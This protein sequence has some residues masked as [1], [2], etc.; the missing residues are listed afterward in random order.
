MDSMYPDKCPTLDCSDR[1]I[2]YKAGQRSVVNF[3]IQQLNLQ[4]KGDMIT[5]V[6]I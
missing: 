6:H 1:A 2:W 4:L 3:L 5:N